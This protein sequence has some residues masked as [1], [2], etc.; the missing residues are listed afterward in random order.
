[1]VVVC[2]CQQSNIDFDKIKW[3]SFTKQ[4]QAFKRQEPNSKIDNLDE[5]ADF[6]IS[7]PNN[8]KKTTLKRAR[9]YKNVIE[10]K[11]GIL[12]TA[13]G[14][15]PDES[16]GEYSK[17]GSIYDEYGRKIGS[18]SNYNPLQEFKLGGESL[19]FFG[20]IKRAF[21]SSWN[22]K[23]TPQEKEILAPIFQGQKF[24]TDK[25]ITPFAPPVGYVAN[26]Q[27]EFLENKYLNDGGSR[28]FM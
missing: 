11:G 1:M 19:G 16:R 7:H 4:F 13:W 24:L 12:H 20:N 14:D 5:F 21:E 8:F 15:E 27:R 10:K 2:P 23:A 28:R 3:G 22:K 18:I 25:I 26:K 17:F 6:I 9:F